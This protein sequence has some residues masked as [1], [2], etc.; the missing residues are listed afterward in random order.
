MRDTLP[1]T[2]NNKESAIVNLDL[3]KNSGTH[4]V[5][6]LKNDNVVHYFDSFGDLKPPREVV[7]YFGPHVKLFYNTEPYQT[8]NQW[9]CGHLCLSF[10]F[11]KK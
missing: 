5:A 3:N 4:W 9:N 10:L 8:Y 7:S 1:Q 11:N 6:Y 2:P